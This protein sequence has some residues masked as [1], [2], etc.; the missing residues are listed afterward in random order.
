MR[1]EFIA[2][3]PGQISNVGLTKAPM[4]ALVLKIPTPL[5]ALLVGVGMWRIA[6]N[7]PG[8]L[9]LTVARVGGAAGVS[10]VGGL[11]SLAGLVAFHRAKTTVNLMKSEA[12]SSLASSSVHLFTRNPMRVG[13]ILVLI[14]WA[15][16]LA[17]SWSLLGSVVF[18]VNIWRFQIKPEERVFVGM[19]GREFAA[20]RSRVRCRL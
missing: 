19:F 16:L 3:M 8:A 10:S 13:L 18:L 2:S 17:A 12:A 7:T 6:L 9:L 5:I 14:G 4:V 20:Y 1:P 15:I 11:F